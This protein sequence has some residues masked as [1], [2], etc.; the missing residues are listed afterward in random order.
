M[1]SGRTGWVGVAGRVACV[2]WHSAV[3]VSWDGVSSMGCCRN[4]LPTSGSSVGHHGADKDRCAINHRPL[5][6][7]HPTDAGMWCMQPMSIY[8]TC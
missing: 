5:L 4:H 8:S 7:L 6:Q 1:L 3:D 2:V